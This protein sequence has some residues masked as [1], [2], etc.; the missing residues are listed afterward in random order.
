MVYALPE[1]SLPPAR[2]FKAMVDVQKG[3]DSEVEK[4]CFIPIICRY[5]HF[6]KDYQ[7]G[8]CMRAAFVQK[9]IQ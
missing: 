3:T 7:F 5:S 4:H 9:L 1:L 8:L 2:T 6:A